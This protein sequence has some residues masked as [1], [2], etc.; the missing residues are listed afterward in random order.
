MLDT[1]SKD[2]NIVIRFR[3]IFLLGMISLLTVYSLISLT[4]IESLTTMHEKYNI[5][6]MDK[7]VDNYDYSNETTSIA[8]KV[9]DLLS[10]TE[11]ERGSYEYEDMYDVFHTVYKGVSTDT[12]YS[13]FIEDYVLTFSDGNHSFTF[14]E[15]VANDGEDILYPISGT[16][17]DSK[18][19][20]N[21]YF[22]ISLSAKESA[23]YDML[24]DTFLEENLSEV[25]SALLP[26]A[27][28]LIILVIYII[29]EVVLPK[30]GIVKLNALD[31]V[32]LEF[33]LLVALILVLIINAIF[34]FT[35]Y[36]ALNK[37]E[38]NSLSVLSL[39][40]FAMY[41]MYVIISNVKKVKVGSFL[42]Y[43]LVFVI[44]RKIYRVIREM[45]V[46]LVSQRNTKKSMIVIGGVCV[47]QFLLMIYVAFEYYFYE[48]IF[49]EML[50][51]V[52][53]CLLLL[54]RSVKI[55]EMISKVI[56]FEKIDEESHKYR[57][58]YTKTMDDLCNLEKSIH[59][60]VEERIVSER[61]KTE[62]I[63]NMSHDLRT[64]LTAIISYIELLKKNGKRSKEEKEYIEILEAKASRLNV[65]IDSLFDLS[66]VSSGATDLE[67]R[68]LEF[69]SLVE[70]T[71]YEI[72]NTK[73]NVVLKLEP[74]LFIS[75]NGETM[76]EVLQNLIVNAFNY[77]LPGTR[78]FISS[79]SENG[80]VICEIT[81]IASY[82]INFTP[83]EIVSRF[84]RGDESRTL[85]GNGLGL[86]I[87]KTYTEANNGVFMVILDGDM[88]RVRMEF[89]QV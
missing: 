88:F 47:L 39:S 25:F 13:S 43:V 3:K 14:G 44:I 74:K 23:E 4:R 45:L 75:A 77:H 34:G 63:T 18:S 22:D 35:Y 70:Q 17:H 73:D 62:L 50:I 6:V 42:D 79:Y 48:L 1:K 52:F 20:T 54:Y 53:T 60:M 8:S 19:D 82:E 83:E 11:F 65:M 12:T 56:H 80:K 38:F 7:V 24:Y 49:V 2:I 16:Y 89:D 87:A 27:I 71:L 51:L 59:N 5:F 32:Y 55:D 78:I 85:E 57:R 58:F 61:T 15:N 28:G 37:I 66:K 9:Y 31:R 67:L 40:L 46:V 64:P 72:D 86:S 21:V 36:Y 10:S 33:Q 30:K 68:E 84:K 81:N 29:V 26:A 69:S 41:C 76:Y